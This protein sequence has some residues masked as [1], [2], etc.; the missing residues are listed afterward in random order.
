[1]W[2]SY[3]QSW[4][5]LFSAIYTVLPIGAFETAHVAR[6]AHSAE[7]SHGYLHVLYLDF[8]N[9]PNS[10]IFVFQVRGKAMHNFFT[11]SVWRVN[12]YPVAGAK[13]P[14]RAILD[15]RSRSHRRHFARQNLEDCVLPVEE[16][17]SKRSRMELSGPKYRFAAKLALSRLDWRQI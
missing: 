10:W 11:N 14:I 8:S 5:F 16:Y 4:T 9:L 15:E 17:G 13:L 3:L 7:N 2:F 12:S 6:V 1:M